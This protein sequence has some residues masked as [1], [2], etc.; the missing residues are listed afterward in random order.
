MGSR[1]GKVLGPPTADI[2]PRF[3][4]SVLAV[5]SV[6]TSS[7]VVGLLAVPTPLMR[8]AFCTH[9]LKSTLCCLKI[10]PST[11]WGAGVLAGQRVGFSRGLQH[12]ELENDEGD[13]SEAFPG[14]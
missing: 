4:W 12:H 2:M 10:A 5:T 9:V 7:R 6:S 3:R 11:S 14:N 8:V 1:L 13:L